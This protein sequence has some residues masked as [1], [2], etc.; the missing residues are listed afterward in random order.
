MSEKTKPA[1]QTDIVA[2][3][4]R[5]TADL[6]T[7]NKERDEARASLTAVSKE[8]DEAKASLA[9]ATAE[10]D[11]ARA[12]LAKVTSERDVLTKTDRDFNARL[13]AEMAKHGIRADALSANSSMPEE[14]K[15]AMTATER[16]LAA[17]GVKTLA[18]LSAKSAQQT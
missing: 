9:T 2:A 1:D 16:V 17:K 4:E 8:L 18:E 13:A 11:Q 5:L 15:K 6:A 10:R 12:D 3:N 14:P 7:S